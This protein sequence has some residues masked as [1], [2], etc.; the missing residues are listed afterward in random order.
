MSASPSLQQDIP[1]AD[2][3]LSEYILE[4][5]DLTMKRN[6]LRSTGQHLQEAYENHPNLCH[7]LHCAERAAAA[8]DRRIEMIERY[9]V[10]GVL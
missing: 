2:A 3:R 10:N 4:M 6:A 9:L 7:W 5:S 1:R 8:L